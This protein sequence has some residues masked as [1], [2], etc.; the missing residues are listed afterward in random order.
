[1]LCNDYIIIRS[2]FG[3]IATVDQYEWYHKMHANSFGRLMETIAISQVIFKIQ[4]N[5]IFPATKL[6]F[7]EKF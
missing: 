5:K 4:A 6:H 1:M 2:I 3:N 7:A